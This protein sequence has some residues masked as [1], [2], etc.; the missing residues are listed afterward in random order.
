[1]Y[2]CAPFELVGSTCPL[3]CSAP[4][5]FLDEKDDLMDTISDRLASIG[6]QLP[7]E[8]LRPGGSY[9]PFVWSGKQLLVAGQ[10]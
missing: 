10:I 9:V 3:T 5:Y 7:D 2:L 1:L 4:I 8:P 6:L